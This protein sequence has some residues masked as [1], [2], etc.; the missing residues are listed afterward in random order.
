MCNLD[1]GELS[2]PRSLKAADSEGGGSA[3]VCRSSS[4]RSSTIEIILLHASFRASTVLT[5]GFLH[6]YFIPLPFLNV[7]VSVKDRG[8]DVEQ[9]KKNFYF[10]VI[11]DR[12][13]NIEVVNNLEKSLKIRFDVMRWEKYGISCVESI[14][15]V[16][17]IIVL[18][19]CGASFP[20]VFQI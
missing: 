13:V 2:S 15:F 10:W 5:K 9:L 3:T 18:Q 12:G 11:C 6:V 17:I 4:S 7:F 19:R 20:N 14:F 1:S 8:L 16:I